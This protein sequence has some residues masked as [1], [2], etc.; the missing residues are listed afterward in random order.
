MHLL[1]EAFGFFHWVGISHY[2]NLLLLGFLIRSGLQILSAHPKLY[3]NE[4][5]T[6]GSEW[7]R[8]TRKRIPSG[9]LWTATDEEVPFYVVGRAS[10]RTDPGCSELRISY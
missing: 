4:H 9:R 1:A 8:L 2:L 5:C 7:L 3:W 6:P 10:E